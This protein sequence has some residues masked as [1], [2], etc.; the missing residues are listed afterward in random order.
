MLVAMI[1]I[2]GLGVGTPSARAEAPGEVVFGDFNGDGLPDFVVL[3]TVSPNL[4]STIVEYGSAP[5]VYL[6]P[7]A[8][9]YLAL[10]GGD[11]PDCPDI[12]VAAD[13]TLDGLDDVGV[14]W[15]RGVPASLGF[16]R[17]ILSPPTFQPTF[18]YTSAITRPTFLGAAVFSPGNRPTPYAIGPGGMVNAVFEGSTLVPGPIRFCSVNGP[19]VQLADWNQDH[20]DGVLLA[21]QNAC[22]DGSSG[23]VT[24]RQDGSSVRLEHDPTGQA[25][26]A[27][28]VVNA[29]GD[30]FPDVRTTTSANHAT[31]PSRYFPTGGSSTGP[32][33]PTAVPTGSPINSARR[34]DEVARLSPS[35]FQP[36]RRAGPLTKVDTPP[37]GI[38][39]T[40]G[41]G[42]QPSLRTPG[43]VVAPSAAGCRR[44][45]GCAGQGQS[46]LVR[47]EL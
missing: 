40:A 5:G 23:V 4:C 25:R 39:P 45:P 41:G 43:D 14:G 37:A 47:Q 42:V 28:R 46:D 22:A 17:L 33:P 11:A 21:Y 6:P 1:V 34:A 44:P 18:T 20:V 30:R 31:A 3:G 7:I 8:Y 35:C 19:T 12:E 15:S 27:A 16:N 9:T 24:I 2:P 36:E 13:L 32:I 29:H 10:G 38:T 26:W